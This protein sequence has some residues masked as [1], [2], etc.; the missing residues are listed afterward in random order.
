MKPL[1]SAIL[2]PSLLAATSA[3]LAVSPQS[4]HAAIV[5]INLNSTLTLTTNTLVPDV[6]GDGSAD[7]ALGTPDV[8][9]INDVYKWVQV[10]IDMGFVKAIYAGDT[11]GHAAFSTV[12]TGTSDNWGMSEDTSVQARYLNQI[13]VTD[14]RINGGATTQ[15]YLEVI[16]EGSMFSGGPSITFGRFVYDNVNTT[17]DPSLVDVGSTYTTATFGAVPEPS[18]L[19]LLGLGAGLAWFRRR[20]A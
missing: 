16:A 1:K 15:G 18:S 10:T 8:Q 5:Q 20:R 19:G 2:T 4:A 9:D 14:S 7:I 6:T 13:S 3:M 12:G 17:L 11:E